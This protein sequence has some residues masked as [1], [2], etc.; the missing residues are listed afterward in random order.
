MIQATVVCTSKV[1]VGMNGRVRV[2][3]E[4]EDGP[5]INKRWSDGPPELQQEIILNRENARNFDVGECYTVV[6]GL[7][8]PA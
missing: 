7:S 4:A 6:I 2:R 3:F 5:L 8:E 1:R